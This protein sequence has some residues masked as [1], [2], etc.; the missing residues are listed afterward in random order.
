MKRDNI[1]TVIAGRRGAGK[2]SYMKEEIV[3]CSSLPKCIIIDTYDNP[4]WR[5]TQLYDTPR[6]NEIV[7]P[8][9]VIHP[10]DFSRWKTGIYRTW[11]SDIKGLFLALNELWN[12][13]IVF[14]DASKYLRG[15]SPEEIREL[16]F[17]SKQQNNDIHFAYHSLEQV[18]PDIISAADYYTIF[19]TSDG[20]LSNKYSNP[21]IQE[22]VNYLKQFKKSDR[23]KIIV[24]V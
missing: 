8:I 5:T 14:D 18:M 13:N 12:T 15:L 6:P 4:S 7:K 1:V 9:P 2:T 17:N 20:K 16:I 3:L 21:D 22:A 10:A 19:Q 24:S 23:K 11:S